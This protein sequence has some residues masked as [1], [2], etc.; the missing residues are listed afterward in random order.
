[1]LSLTVNKVNK[2]IDLRYLAIIAS[3]WFK[4]PQLTT[5][6]LKGINI[7]SNSNIAMIGDLY[8]VT[9]HNI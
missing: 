7:S 9:V 2:A 1:M 4:L 5:C 6:I 3:H 8:A